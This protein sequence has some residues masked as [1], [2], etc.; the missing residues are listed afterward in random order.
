MIAALREANVRLLKQHAEKD[1]LAKEIQESQASYIEQ[2]RPWSDISHR[3][4]LNS[5]AQQ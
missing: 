5:Q 2:V 4:Y 3:A 1:A